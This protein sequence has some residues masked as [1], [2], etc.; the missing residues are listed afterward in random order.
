M[1]ALPSE[2][3]KRIRFDQMFETEFA[4][5]WRSLARL[6]VPPRDLEDVTHDAFIEVYRRLDSYDPSRPVRP[7]LFAFAFRLAS[8]YRRLA[9]HRVELLGTEVERADAALSADEMIQIQETRQ[10]VE[11]AVSKIDPERRPVFIL[12]DLDEVPIPEVARVLELPLNTA[13]SRLRLARE[14]FR[15]AIQRQARAGTMSPASKETS[16]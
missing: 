10:L 11:R 4:Y 2:D 14:E 12:H 13:Y 9:R 16:P 1:I 15:A 7:W 3:T 6:G 8:D 5:M